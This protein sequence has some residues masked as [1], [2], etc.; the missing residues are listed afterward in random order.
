MQETIQQLQEEVSCIE[1]AQSVF[2]TFSD[3]LSTAQNNFSTVAICVDVVDHFAM[4][5]KMK[6]LEVHFP[7][8][9]AFIALL[10]FRLSKT[11]SE[12]MSTS[13]II[14]VKISAFQALQADMEQGHTYLK[15]MREKT[16]KAMGFLEEPE[17]EQ[18]KEEVD[19][20]LL[21]LQQLMEAL[22][23]EHSSLE[24]CLLL[25]KDFMDKY[26]AQSQWLMETKYLLALSVEP[27]AELY[28]KKAQLAKYKV[29]LSL[30]FLFSFSE[31][32]EQQKQMTLCALFCSFPICTDHP[33]DCTVS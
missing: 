19:T 21:Q 16:E 4:E 25:S 17:A 20:R 3:W 9:R 7:T 1:E 28:Q 14:R 29:T 8:S 23:T 2:S 32:A 24:K 27:K 15:T 6:K 30:L 10:L 11:L 22:R 31:N 18:L 5:R 26:K 33:P 13:T 12:E